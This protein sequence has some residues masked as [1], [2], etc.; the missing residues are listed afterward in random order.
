LCCRSGGAPCGDKDE[1]CARAGI[2]VVQDKL[3]F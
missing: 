3:D 1:A 2:K